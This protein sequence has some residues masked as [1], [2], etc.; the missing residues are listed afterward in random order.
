[1]VLEDYCIGCS[2]SAYTCEDQRLPLPFQAGDFGD[3]S[4]AV[5]SLSYTFVKKALWCSVV[6]LTCRHPKLI[7]SVGICRAGLRVCGKCLSPSVPP[8]PLPFMV[9]ILRMLPIKLHK[10]ASLYFR[11]YCLRSLT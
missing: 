5:G 1:M 4:A 3:L 7:P 2:L 9:L 11:V 10:Q 8:P 6:I